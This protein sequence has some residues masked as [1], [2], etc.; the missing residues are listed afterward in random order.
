MKT[1]S[2]NLSPIKTA[3]AL[4]R[5]SEQSKYGRLTIEKSQIGKLSGRKRLEDSTMTRIA[6]ELEN[7]G[8]YLLPGKGSIYLLIDTAVASIQ[9]KAAKV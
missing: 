9:W 2:R 3:T 7:R 6:I 8:Y 5:L 1:Q 4:I